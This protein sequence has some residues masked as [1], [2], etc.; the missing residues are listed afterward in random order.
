MGEVF[1]GGYIA[2]GTKVLKKLPIRVIDFSN[3]D[4]KLLHDT[5]SKIQQKLIGIQT[6]IDKNINN[7]RALIPLKRKFKTEKIK[8]D[9]LLKS[10]YNLE[11]DN[12]I[13]LISEIYAIN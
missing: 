13:P 8:L 11:D 4:D 5:I 9:N 3:K 12:L 2:R 10:L 6:G 1:I 7:N